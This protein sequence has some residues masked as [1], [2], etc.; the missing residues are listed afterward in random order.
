MLRRWARDTWTGLRA[1][2]DPSPLPADAVA[3][4]LNPTSLAP[5]TSPSNIAGYLWSVV[6]A[7]DLGLIDETECRHRLS[8]LLATLSSLPRHEPSGLLLNW[9]TT[10][11][12]PLTRW[13]GTG[14]R[15]TPFVSTVDN[16]WLAA[17]LH[18]AA[19]AVPALAAEAEAVHAPMRFAALLDPSPPQG[20]GPLLRGGFWTRSPRR[21]TVRA[22]HGPLTE[23]VH[24]TRHHYALLNSETRIAYYVAMIRGDL[25]PEGLRPLMAPQRTYCG[26]RVIATCGGSMFEA[27]AP[28][29]FVPETEWAPHTWGASHAAT[30][31]AHQA[32]ARARGFAAWGFSPA[33]CPGSGYREFGVA[34]IAWLPRGYRST[35]RGEPVVAAH[36]AAL[37]LLHDPD[38]ATSNLRR[39]ETEFGCY[40]PGGF[41]DSVGLTTR[42]TAGRHLAFDTAMT[43]AALS[44]ALGTGGLRRWFCTPQVVSVLRPA[45]TAS[46]SEATNNSNDADNCVSW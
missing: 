21:E 28:E 43:L 45:V 46:P 19:A 9:Y 38:A 34:P 36:A 24:Y 40:G 5:H 12:E 25:G 30:V 29:L 33:A 10:C 17:A 7:R 2:A 13:P 26:H 1:L 39:L 37:A 44:V 4:D 32:Y 42:T 22:A 27:L 3:A 11:G 6:C 8:A 18:T 23:P 14:R 20:T 16:A 31:A 15:V 41:I 35:Y